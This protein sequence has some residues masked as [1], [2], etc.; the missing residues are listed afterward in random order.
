[1]SDL[2]KETLLHRIRVKLY[3]NFL[4]PVN[5]A[6]IART[7]SEKII[8]ME[9]VCNSLKTRGFQGNPKEVLEHVR[10]YYEEMSFLLCD[11]WGIN[12]GYYSVH[13]NIG[14][15]FNSV[16]EAHDHDKHPISFR[17]IVRSK[18]RDLIKHIEVSVDGLADTGGYIDTFTDSEEEDFVNN[19]FIPGNMFAIHGRKI[20]L[21]GD[22]K[23]VGVYFVP[24]E[25]P[26][27]A[28]KVARIGDNTPTRITGIAPD[29]EH[30]YNRIEIR[31]QF[32]GD[33][34]KVLKTPR[35]ITSTFMLEVV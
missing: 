2:T 29:T 25:D 21:A 35:T 9:E 5:G 26:S 14:G 31:T 11:G 19:Y 6:Y 1:M 10:L 13:P 12:N 20:K 30:A 23:S 18:L 32:S 4:K 8:S 3:Q 16:K 17:F 22:D 33:P 24:V 34:N 15:T 27:K 28:V 7:D